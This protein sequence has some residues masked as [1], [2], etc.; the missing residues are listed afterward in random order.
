MYSLSYEKS[1]T[2]I[3]LGSA[4]GFGLS[5]G[6][7]AV[8]YDRTRL[9]VFADNL[10]STNLGE[11]SDVEIPRSVTG[12]ISYSPYRHTEVGFWTRR[13]ARH[14]FEY[15]VYAST[16]PFKYISFR[17]S[18]ATNPDR[19]GLGLGVHYSGINLDYALL[20]NPIL[21]LSHAVTLSYTR[22]K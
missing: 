18:C 16:T 22:S 13:E 12:L 21:P 9:S 3:D 15:S 7:T 19:V 2:G 6:L 8:L 14:D 17:A 10:T 20:T 4:S 1:V 11:N 5:A